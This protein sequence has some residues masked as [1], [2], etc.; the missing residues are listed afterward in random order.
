LSLVLTAASSFKKHE[1]S[2]YFVGI[3][4]IAWG[5]RRDTGMANF[6]GE[7]NPATGALR[8]PHLTNRY[9]GHGVSDNGLPGI[10]AG[11]GGCF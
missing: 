1:T 7:R 4:V 5:Y 10:S 2:Q 8:P 6:P 11:G 9:V 3:G